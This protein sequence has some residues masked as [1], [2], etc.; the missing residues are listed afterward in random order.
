MT[1]G[2]KLF[3][4]SHKEREKNPPTFDEMFGYAVEI[5]C[6]GYVINPSNIEFFKKFTPELFEE[7]H[8]TK[9]RIEKKN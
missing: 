9:P 2:L 1:D 4:K 5:Y 3:L 7:E 6:E 8:G